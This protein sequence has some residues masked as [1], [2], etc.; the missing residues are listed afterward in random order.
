MLQNRAQHSPESQCHL[1]D[2]K[3]QVQPWLIRVLSH[4]QLWNLHH[5][6]LNAHPLISESTGNE[7]S[8]TPEPQAA[9]ARAEYI[10]NREIHARKN[11]AHA[12]REMTSK[13]NKYH[14]FQSFVVGQYVTAIISRLDRAA[15]D[16]NRILCRIVDNAGSNEQPGYELR[17]LHGLLKGLHPTSALAAVSTAVQQSQGNPISINKTGNEIT[18]AH[19]ASQ[20]ST[21]NKVGVSRNCKTGCGTR[22]CRCYRNDLKCSIYCHNTECDCSNLKPPTERTEISL[23]P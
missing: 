20:A 23:L 14:R 11:N 12:R 16:N 6:P 2:N 22:R 1:C 7:L 15:T 19:A 3:H 18:L 21:S 13:Y 9:T 17:F 10:V 5:L 8:I 4:H